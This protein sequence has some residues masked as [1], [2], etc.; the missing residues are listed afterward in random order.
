MRFIVGL[1]AA[2]L[3]CGPAVWADEPA[4]QTSQLQQLNRAS[5]QELKTI[6]GQAGQPATLPGPG[7]RLA[8]DRLNRQQEA[9]Q[10]RLQ[11]SQRRELL[12][13]NHRARTGPPTPGWQ[14]RLD[15]IHRQQQFQLQQQYQLNQ[16][17]MQQGLPLR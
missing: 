11:E 14:P 16:F 9:A 7:E 12:I 5:R 1:L 4:G 6:Q 15:A 8:R 3:S 13:Q 2:S 17:R 10:E